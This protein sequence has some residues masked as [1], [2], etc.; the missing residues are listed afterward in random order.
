MPPSVSARAADYVIGEV[1]RYWA[2]SLE[3]TDRALSAVAAAIK[4]TDDGTQLAKLRRDMDKILDRRMVLE[5]EQT[6][7]T[8]G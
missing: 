6:L 1:A 3:L 5:L 2:P 8:R 7:V 4:R